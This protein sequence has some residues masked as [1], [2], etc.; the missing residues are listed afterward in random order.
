MSNHQFEDITIR[1]GEFLFKADDTAEFLYFI[2]SGEVI[3]FNIKDK[4]TCFF[5]RLGAKDIAGAAEIFIDSKTYGHYAYVEETCKAIRLPKSEIN[6]SLSAKPEWVSDV[7][8]G[9]SDK[10]E[11]TTDFLVSHR[12]QDEDLLLGKKVDNEVVQRILSKLKS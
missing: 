9:M 10:L 7:V 2:K 8:K 6:K 12:I 4:K 3:L 5:N 1:S 11:K